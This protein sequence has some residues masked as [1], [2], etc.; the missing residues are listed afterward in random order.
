[1]RENNKKEQAPVKPSAAQHESYGTLSVISFLIWPV[2][3]V[4]GIVYLTKSD[5]VERKLGEHLIVMSVFGLI[6][7][8]L[9]FYVLLPMLAYSQ[10]PSFY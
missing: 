6:V 7:A 4:L 1:M 10:T 9:L 8:G 2:G 3:L 5:A